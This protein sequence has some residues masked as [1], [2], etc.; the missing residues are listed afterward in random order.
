MYNTNGITVNE[1]AARSN[2]SPMKK[3]PNKLKKDQS[4]CCLELKS[5]TSLVSSDMEHKINT[6]NK[7]G[8][9]L[10]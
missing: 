9:N 7:T 1:D 10:C 3:M 2:K 6:T 8:L 5:K 4:T